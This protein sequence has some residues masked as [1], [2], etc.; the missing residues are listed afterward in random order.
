MKTVHNPLISVIVPCYKTESYLP[1]CIESILENTYKNIELILI[2]DGSPDKCGEIC[3]K[4]ANLDKRILVIHQDNQGQSVA[5]N[6]GVKI[7]SGMYICFVDSDDYVDKQ[8]VEY[9]YY[10]LEK[11]NAKMS[12]AA[13]ILP[14][15]EE[16]FYDRDD[17]I[18]EAAKGTTFGV[19]PWSKLYEKEI[20]KRIPYPEGKHHEDLA[21][22]V[23]MIYEAGGVA[24][25]PNKQYHYER[26]CDS[27]TKEKIY[28]KHLLDGFWAASEE[29]TFVEKKCPN[30]R[31][32]AIYRILDMAITFMPRIFISDRSK[33]REYFDIMQDNIFFALSYVSNNK[34]NSFSK[35][36]LLLLYSASNYYLWIV[37]CKLLFIMHKL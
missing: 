18:Y 29:L 34:A 20:V 28:E 1:R 14:A 27:I 8:Y 15:V 10:L 17:A 23:K 9:L 26:R 33:R 12:I 11:Y 7:S 36:E 4:Y 3:D 21:V 35:K 2:D 31:D 22:C 16:K 32:A 5:R 13:T 37:I 6:N 25:G 30:A 19:S 24:Y